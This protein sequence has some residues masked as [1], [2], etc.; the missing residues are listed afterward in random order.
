MD[1]N[2]TPVVKLGDVNINFSANATYNNN[3]VLALFPGINELAIGGTNQFTQIAASSPEAFNYA[4]VGQ[5]AFVFKLSDYKRDA[6]GKVIVD[7]ATGYPSLQ[8]SIVTRGRS[9]PTWIVGIN[10]SVSWKGLTLGMTWDYRGGHNVYHGIGSDMDFT[11]IS[12]RSA[13]FGRERFVFPELCI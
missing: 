7:R 10:P 4:I 13:Q 11:G 2:I 1:L 5:P 12:A 6:N 9:L 3:E 8:D